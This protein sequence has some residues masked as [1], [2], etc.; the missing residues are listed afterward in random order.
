MAVRL[1]PDRLFFSSSHLSGK[2]FSADT[3]DPID[4]GFSV[5]PE[6]KT[7]YFRD[8]IIVILTIRDAGKFFALSAA[9]VF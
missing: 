5:R 9:F 4:A 2:F 6:K 1:S 7:E 8:R 3:L